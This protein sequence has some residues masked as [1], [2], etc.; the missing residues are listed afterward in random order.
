MELRNFFIENVFLRVYSDFSMTYLLQ[1]YSL[2]TTHPFQIHSFSLS[3][4]KVDSYILN[5]NNN[6]KV[7]IENRIG[8]NKH[9]RKI[10]QR[11]I[12]EAHIHTVTS[13]IEHTHK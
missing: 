12:Q 13:S 5:N 1:N 2:S 8:Y 10:N 3:L 9:T 6:S 4:I 7:K 11:K